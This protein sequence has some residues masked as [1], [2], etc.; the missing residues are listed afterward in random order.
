M[1]KRQLQVAM[2]EWTRNM[3]LPLTWLFV[4]GVAV[5]L[6]LI[7]PFGTDQVMILPVA[8][9]YWL[10][11]TA[12]SYAIGLFVNVVVSQY[13]SGSGSLPRFGLAAALTGIGVS[14][15]VVT[16]N[17]AFFSHF[18]E[19]AQWPEIFGSVF[20]ISL[21]ITGLLA[22]V[23]AHLAADA[24][25]SGRVPLMDRL[26]LDKRGTLLALS[27]ED[28]YVRVH[29]DKGE[30]LLLMRLSDA[31]RETG[32][33]PGAQVHRSYWAAW[34]AVASVRRDGAR[35][36]LT[37]ASGVEIP[38]SRSNLHKIREAGLLPR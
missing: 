6:A 7:G 4:I 13:L 23:D 28:H 10:L 26:P 15:L 38:V 20:L 2:R 17:W 21:V 18:P 9:A 29:T 22:A 32:E 30:D 3:R 16:L 37:L 27:V 35:A 36:V 8:L 19:A 34:D 1:S 33:T 11:I 31:I 25:A 12:G 5:I 24:P 14:V